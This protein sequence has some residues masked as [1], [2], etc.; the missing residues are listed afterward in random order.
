MQISHVI[1][2]WKESPKQPTFAILSIRILVKPVPL[3]NQYFRPKD[4]ILI[5]ILE[6]WD[7]VRIRYFDHNVEVLYFIA[8]FYINIKIE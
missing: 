7:K 8:L 6:L 4:N 3:E 5:N 2:L 1:K